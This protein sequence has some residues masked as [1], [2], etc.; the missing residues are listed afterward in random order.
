MK[1]KRLILIYILL[2][3]SFAFSQGGDR[4][5]GKGGNGETSIHLVKLI[6]RH[7]YTYNKKDCFIAR[8]SPPLYEKVCKTISEMVMKGMGQED[9]L[10]H[11]CIGNYDSGPMAR[12]I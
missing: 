3:T 12:D 4:V 1:I 2:G 6:L 5:G 7:G 11:C 8:Q 9:F 10:F